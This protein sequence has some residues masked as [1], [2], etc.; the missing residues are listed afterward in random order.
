MSITPSSVDTS[1]AA[2]DVDFSVHLTDDAAGVDPGATSVTVH[3]P[4]GSPT[5]TDGLEL[6][7]G[8]ALDGTYDASITLPR[9]STQG[10]WTVEVEVADNSGN[11]DLWTTPELAD[12]GPSSRLRSNRRRRHARADAGELRRLAGLH[13]HLGCRR[14]RELRPH[15]D[16]RP[17]RSRSGGVARDRSGSRRR[18]DRSSRRS[19]L[20]SGTSLNGDYQ[21]TITIPR[22]APHGTWK[23]ELL[24]VDARRK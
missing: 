8:D 23:I 6:A 1:G 7:T 14:G 9:Y 5:F 18:A 21:A 4:D 10:T 11:H 12:G 15:R 22:Y 2:R 19:S 3:S 17:R 13:R 20:V 16:R 24:L